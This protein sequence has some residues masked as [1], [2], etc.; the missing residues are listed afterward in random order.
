MP[1][2]G[3]RTTLVA[4]LIGFVTAASASAEGAPKADT[5]KA[6]PPPIN[7]TMKEAKERLGII[8]FPAKGQDAKLQE[9]EEQECLLWAADQAGI[10]SSTKAKDPNAAADAAAAKTDSAT[11]G[12]GVK[13]AAKGAAVGAVIGSISGNAGAGAAYG[14]AGGALAGRSARKQA[15]AQSAEKAKKQAEAENQAKKDAV[16][17]GMTLCLESKGY[18]IK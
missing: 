18:T 1:S 7:M 5:T 12:A 11:A 6:A 2:S 4:T 17:K 14:A 15:T 3:F 13:T 10:T 16:K 8:V 9:A